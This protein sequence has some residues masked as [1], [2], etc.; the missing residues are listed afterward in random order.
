MLA[1]NRLVCVV[2]VIGFV[3]ACSGGSDGSG[4]SRSK[5]VVELTAGEE[6]DLCDFIVDV[7][8]GPR[9]VMCGPDFSV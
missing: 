9:T 1:M 3:S 8:D 2:V 6:S 4:V 5:R 7:Q